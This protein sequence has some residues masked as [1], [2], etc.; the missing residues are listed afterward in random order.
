M[1]IIRILKGLLVIIV[2]LLV[3]LAAALGYLYQHQE[4]ITEKA[5]EWY[6]SNYT[7]DLQLGK[8]SLNSWR[9]WPEV[10]LSIAYFSLTDTSY[11]T[12]SPTLLVDTLTADFSLADIFQREITLKKIVLQGGYLHGLTLANGDANTNILEALHPRSPDQKK[13]GFLRLR[14]DLGLSVTIK[15]FDLVRD[16]E[17]KNKRMAGHIEQL[18]AQVTLSDTVVMA[19]TVFD[20]CV[21]G[22]GFNLDK[23]SFIEDTPVSGLLSLHY[24]RQRS[25][26]EIP[27]FP[28]QLK[29]Q[30]FL[31]E[32]CLD[33][34]PSGVFFLSL[35]NEQTDFQV[36]KGLLT[37]YLQD[38]LASYQIFDPIATATYIRGEFESG[39]NPWVHVDFTAIDNTV[40][41]DEEVRFKKVN[42][43]GSFVNRISEDPAIASREDRRNLKLTV[44]ELHSE[45]MGANL[46]F[47]NSAFKSTPEVLTSLDFH[48]EANGQLDDLN[49]I[50]GNENFFF[51]GGKFKAQLNMD[52][53]ATTLPEILKSTEGRLTMQN[54]KVHYR[55]AGVTVPLTELDVLLSPEQATVPSIRIPLAEGQEIK[56]SGI[57]KNFS[58]LI[59]EDKKEKVESDLEIYSADLNLDHFLT[60]IASFQETSEAPSTQPRISETAKGIYS[61]F[62]PRLSILIDQFVYQK[63]Q[64]HNI[65]SQLSFI[66]DH[67]LK[68]DTTILFSGQSQL[69]LSGIFDVPDSLHYLKMNLAIQANG[70]TKD[71][72][73]TF[74]ND[75]FLFQDGDYQFQ[76]KVNGRIK[77][78]QSLLYATRGHLRVQNTGIFFV[79]EALNFSVA[80]ID[81]N[82]AQHDITLNTLQLAL[83]S[84]GN[85]VL[86]GQVENF[87]DILTEKETPLVQSFI[88]LQASYLDYADFSGLFSSFQKKGTPLDTANVGSNKIKRSTLNLYRKFHPELDIQIDSF[89]HKSALVTDLRS[90]VAFQGSSLLQFADMHFE[91][92][93]SPVQLNANLSLD[94]DTITPLNFSLFTEYFDLGTLMETYHHFGLTALQ[95]A[96]KI[97]GK[98]SLNANL[99]GQIT[100]ASGLDPK[101]LLGAV[102]F[103]LHEAELVNFEPIQKIADK[104][105]RTERFESIR[106]APVTDTLY[107]TQEVIYIPRMEIQSTAFNLF[108]EGH[109]N[110]DNNTNLWISVP[111]HNFNAWEEG[112]SIPPKMGYYRAGAKLYV[113]VIG[114]DENGLDYKFHL[115]KKKLYHHQAISPLYRHDHRYE[116]RLRRLIRKEKRVGRRESRKR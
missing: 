17:P 44:E 33:I 62:Q 37:P 35:F 1:I 29:D 100:D 64:G 3:L 115:S 40:L 20:A 102:Q 72:N 66:N 4:I 94:K 80:S 83:P 43:S 113:E 90:K 13:E 22:L 92:R 18:I 84:G 81:L 27:Q 6:E 89:Q 15:D 85:L 21:E 54:T 76:G 79:P 39:A 88:R 114:N 73:K 63:W 25:T 14:D 30:V 19:N 68:L 7:G 46:F 106:F 112:D 69:V 98:V 103:T 67:Q 60:L 101:S 50:L 110:Y 16:S 57:V 59:F 36:T 109:I 56:I 42:G 105:F 93:G 111:W 70:N 104:F 23:G 34:G 53:P 75:T 49:K 31:T 74:S 65:Q 82:L 108:L 8:L 71:F 95:S 28:L 96:Q 2:V 32:A 97:A 11:A 10:T 5:E 58:S 47:K 86:S 55:P 26:I 38:K 78:W 12:A 116:R 87:M 45:Y 52:G 9:E 77:D 91:Y 61:T 41:I 107:I 48:L 24:D 51:V 99:S